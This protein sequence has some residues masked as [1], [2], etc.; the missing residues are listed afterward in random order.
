MP[1]TASGISINRKGWS[2]SI[3]LKQV[4]EWSRRAGSQRWGGLM[5]GGSER[6]RANEK[7]ALGLHVGRGSLRR[8]RGAAMAGQQGGKQRGAG[9]RG[10]N[11]RCA[12]QHQDNENNTK[13]SHI[14]FSCLLSKTAA[15]CSLSDYVSLRAYRATNNYYI[16]YRKQ[17]RHTAKELRASQVP[18]P[19]GTKHL[20]IGTRT[21]P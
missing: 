11:L 16:E 1:F 5:C 9:N 20:V 14:L 21:L 3:R 4:K 7:F 19:R 8:R 17:A 13:P 18:G 15:A 10:G 12:H 2:S 6:V